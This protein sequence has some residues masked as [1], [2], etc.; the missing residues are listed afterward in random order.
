MNVF[1]PGQR[2]KFEYLNHRGATETRDVIFKGLDYGGNEWYPERQ[3]F[4]RCWDVSR[5]ADRSFALAR[6]NG[7]AVE[8]LPL[9]CIDLSACLA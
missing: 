2:L 9:G 8:V 1:L 4:M 6:I 3:W 7:D 5:N